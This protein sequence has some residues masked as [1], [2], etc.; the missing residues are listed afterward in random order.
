MLADTAPRVRVLLEEARRAA[1]ARDRAGAHGAPLGP[2]QGD[3]Q[4]AAER[5]ERRLRAALRIPALEAHFSAPWPE[6][7]RAVLPTAFRRPA[8]TAGIWNTVVAWCALESLGFFHDSQRPAPA[9][10]ELFDRLRLRL[11]MAE[12]FA[13]AGLSG[14]ERWRAA[15][16]LRASFA[17]PTW[18]PES[19]AG[20]PSEV[21]WS[22]LHDPDVA[23]LVGVN[24]YE[25]VRYLQKEAFERLL[26]WMALPRLLAIAE[27]A[28]I[29]VQALSALERRLQARI[30]AAANSG[31]RVEAL[32]ESVS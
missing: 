13:N 5:C 31:Y 28:E 29:D 21:P 17:H 26:W 8:E 16:R 27:P 1:E 7:A 15:A 12:A 18:I 32:F 4:K 6:E 22:W 2:W 23:W 24:E 3:L 20:H 14:E 19:Q 10:A 11:P 9:A 30:H 25:G